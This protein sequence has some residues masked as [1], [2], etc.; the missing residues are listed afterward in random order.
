M[1]N[2]A[3][4]GDSTVEVL[5]EYANSIIATLRDPL[6]VLDR[7]L[8]IISSNHAF[9]ANFHIKEDEVTGRKLPDLLN[10][11]W[12]IPSLIQQLK[13]IIPEKKVLRDFE[14]EH[15]FSQ[16]GTRIMLLNARQLHVPRL[17]AKMITAGAAEAG[18]GEEGK[19]EL[20]LLSFEDITERKRLQAELV[21]SE[22]RYRR[23]FETS[24]DALL[25]VHKT[26]GDILNSNDS[27]RE[28]LGYSHD[29]LLKKKL[30]QIG[31]T[32]DS[33][34]YQET[35]SSLERDGVVHY[36]EVIIKSKQ[37][38]IITAE[39]FLV[40]RAKVVQCNIR[41][42]TKSK[43]IQEEL[44]DKM[45]D[46]ERFSKFAIDRELKMEELEKK[47]KKLEEMLKRK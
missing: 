26:Q 19:E 38:R 33:R 34:D 15:T 20:I 47:D 6:L 39:V 31:V 9:Y 23:A 45:E 30:W 44:K 11:E 42:I 27:V 40:D 35:L 5:L 10:G 2:E 16:L 18:E 22:E 12:N 36:E 17:V 13:V 21:A 8:R 4:T 1:K 28:M 46:L 43:R 32:K 3:Y 24:R 29:E 7:D 37:G 25:L 14:L 41:D